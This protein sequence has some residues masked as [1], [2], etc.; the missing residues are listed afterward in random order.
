M[1]SEELLYSHGADAYKGISSDF[2]R[3]AKEESNIQIQAEQL[4]VVFHFFSLISVAQF[5]ME[6][7][8]RRC[9]LAVISTFHI[10]ELW[11][12]RWIKNEGELTPEEI[13][14][15]VYRYSRE[16][17]HSDKNLERMER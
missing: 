17:E 14:E 6:G 4:L 7:F 12:A 2:K 8:M 13:V 5:M 3:W 9:R 11:K 16:I 10:Y 15:L 1:E